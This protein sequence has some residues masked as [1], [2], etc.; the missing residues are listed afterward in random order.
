MYAVNLVVPSWRLAGYEANECVYMCTSSINTSFIQF[1]VYSYYLA[2]DD[3]EYS[4]DTDILTE[5]TQELR[6]KY[7]LYSCD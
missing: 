2:S 6:V 7:R 1:H 5:Q 4:K 3:G